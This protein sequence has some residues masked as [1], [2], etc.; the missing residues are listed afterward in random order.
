MS[1]NTKKLKHP[2]EK[3]F[4]QQWGM[5]EQEPAEKKV[6]DTVRQE[7][8]IW[9]PKGWRHLSVRYSSMPT[10]AMKRDVAE[11]LESGKIPNFDDRMDRYKKATNWKHK[12]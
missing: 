10:L 4:E 9:T 2:S 5:W 8:Y 11:Y 1:K 3:Q 12:K 6:Y 7:T